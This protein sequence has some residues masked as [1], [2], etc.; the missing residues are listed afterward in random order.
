MKLTRTLF[1]Y[2]T[3]KYKTRLINNKH[4][5]SNQHKWKQ[6]WEEPNMGMEGEN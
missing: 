1:K 4:L 2:T 5:E 6:Q 3:H